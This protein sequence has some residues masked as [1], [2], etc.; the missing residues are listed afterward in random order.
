[1]GQLPKLL[2]V[3]SNFT[4]HGFF[5]SLGRD[6]RARSPNTNVP[7]LVL[8]LV[9]ILVLV[10]MARFILRIPG[11]LVV[12]VGSIALIAFGLGSGNA[13]IDLIAPVPSRA[14]ARRRCPPSASSAALSAGLLR[15]R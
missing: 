8:S 10:L 2:G 13:G 7:T 3:E 12:V 6:D 9:V 11:Q 1:M 15:S 4:G 5:R 14:R